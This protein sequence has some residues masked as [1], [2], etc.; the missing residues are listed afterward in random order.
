MRGPGRPRGGVVAVIGASGGVG[1]STLAALL[2]ARSAAPTT[3]VDLAPASGGLDVTLGIETAPG[4]RWPDLVVAGPGGADLAQLPRWR[5]VRVLSADRSGVGPDGATLA[6]TWEPLL[7]GGGR[8][9]V[10]LP[11]A[12]L[13]GAAVVL[14]TQTEVVLLVGQDVRGVA[15]AI[16]TRG[17]LG[18]GAVRV[19]LRAQRRARVAPAEVEAALGAPVCAR[20]PHARTLAD[21]TDA[22]LGPLGPD[23]TRLGRAVADLDRA[24]GAW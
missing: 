5:G 14:P 7:A 23:R 9:V 19:V 11:G 24:L 17:L 22:G 15:G 10:D 4:P 16:A 13:A 8:V 2:A 21:A 3:L 6:A 18:P 1:A 12:A 20:I